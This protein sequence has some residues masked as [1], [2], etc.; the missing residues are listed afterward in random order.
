MA[1]W[2]IV[3]SALTCFVVLSLTFFVAAYLS[4]DRGKRFLFYALC[5]VCCT[6]AFYSKGF[7]GVAIPALAVLTFL[8]FEKNLREILRMHLWLG[9]GVFLVLTLPWFLS[10]WQ[11]GGAEY[12]KVFLVHNH[13]DRFAGGSTGHAKPFYY[14]LTQ[15]PGG[16]LPWSLLLVPVFYWS[17]KKTE[18]PDEKSR[19]G[20]LFA[21]CWFIAGFIFLSLAST[22]RVLYLMPVF[23]P[24]S[25]LTANYIE[26]SFNRIVFRK[27]EEF[28]ALLFGAVVLM[29][30]LATIPL[31]FYA[32]KK[33]GLGDPPTET[34]AT[35][36]WLL[37]ALVLSL[38]AL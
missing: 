20:V 15:F 19:K 12:L 31:Y 35:I 17:F 36:R 18:Y 28:F 23:A 6:L 26:A 14:Y 2:V 37:V 25:L 38:M 11:Q 30:S 8:I 5:Y 3:D 1:H 27:F 32:L 13:L 22:K 29:V 9:I 4:P 10:L 21:K 24:I 34:A 33:Y 16:Y 7:I